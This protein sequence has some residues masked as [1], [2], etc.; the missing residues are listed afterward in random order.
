MSR[1]FRRSIATCAA[2]VTILS[3]C[4][5]PP[6]ATEVTPSATPSAQAFQAC[7]LTA[8]DQPGS[9]DALAATGLT[10]AQQTLAATI[11]QAKVAGADE[12]PRQLQA[13]VTSGCD[14]IFAV[15]EQ[16]GDAIAAAARTNPQTKFALIDAAPLNPPS[17]LKPIMFAT[18]EVAFQAGYLAA[19]TSKTGKVGVFAGMYLPAVTSYLEG[20]AQGVE[21]FNRQRGAKV[22]L[23][24][25]NPSN[26]TGLQIRSTQPFN[27]PAA[28]K[29]LAEELIG[30]GADVIMPVAGQSGTG[31][32]EA[33]RAKDGVKVIWTDTDGCAA[34]AESCAVIVG[35]AA[36]AADQALLG[37]TKSAAAGQWSAGIQVANLRNDGVTLLPG[38]QAQIDPQLTAE[39]DAIKRAI[40]DGSIQVRSDSAIG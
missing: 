24:G 35:S 27:D 16:A 15:G 18:Q 7:L 26:K 17:N 34:H 38:K 32:L 36:K 5:Q 14:L 12:Y 19:G 25:W 22:E 40:I 10:K 4:A 33:A 3:G 9:L 2:V 28:G 31:A 37:L 11:N 1:A 8:N 29:Q 13:M 30:Q 39:L 21:Y 6:S 20:F 23:L